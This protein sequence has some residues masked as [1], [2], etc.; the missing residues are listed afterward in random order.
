MMPGSVPAALKSFFELLLPPACPFCLQT[1]PPESQAFFCHRCTTLIMP[2][3]PARCCRC[4][5]PFPARDRSSHLCDTCSRQLPPYE[6]VFSA[7]IYEAGLRDMIRRFKFERG[8]DLDRPLGGL[9]AQALDPQVNPD[10]I[11]AVPLHWRRLRQRS[12]NQSLLLARELGR[13][14][15]RPVASELLLRL[16]DTPPQQG[17]NARERARNLNGAFI[18]NGKLHGERV[19]LVDDVMTTGATAV[20]CSRALLEAGAAD[21][22]VA[23]VARAGRT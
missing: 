14:L 8:H 20:A 19:L 1:L 13:R 7:G 15:E 22:R 18:C 11:V 2:M 23:V 4:A 3:P 16:R 9:L 12:Y 6:A 17:L 21:V 10:I 5:L